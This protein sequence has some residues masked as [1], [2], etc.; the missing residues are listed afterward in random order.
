MR[1]LEPPAGGRGPGFT[2][3]DSA[4]RPQPSQATSS[5]T[6]WS[7]ADRQ[8]SDAVETVSTTPGSAAYAMPTRRAQTQRKGLI[9]QQ[10][11]L[12]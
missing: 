1:D 6:G 12:F 10:Q 4:T 9:G 5:A 2:Y 8:I 11:K 3:D 7:D